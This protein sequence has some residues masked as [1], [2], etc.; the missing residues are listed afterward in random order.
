MKEMRCVC[1]AK[2]D[3]IK[4]DV[5][6]FDESILKFLE[7]FQSHKIRF[8][9]FN[10]MLKDVDAYYCPKC[11]EEIL[12]TDQLSSTREKLREI[13]PDF[14]AFSLR[15]KVTQMGNS[16]SIPLSKEVAEFM[17]LRKGEDVKIMVKNR[18]RL[19]IDVCG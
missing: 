18:R 11:R 5:E 14:E 7:E 3:E 1:G 6:L 2:V 8:T 4:T 10:V 9:N 12:T 17:H 13:L 19:I 15:K 16:L